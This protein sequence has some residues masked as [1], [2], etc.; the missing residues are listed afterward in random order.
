MIKFNRFKDGKAFVLTMSYDD[1][2]TADRRL[3]EIFNKYGIK[4][5]FHLNSGFLGVNDHINADEVKSLYE[6]HEVSCHSAHHPFLTQ[7][8]DI[9][10]M[11]EVLEDRKT[12]E[13]LCGYVVRGMSYPYGVYSDKVIEL[14]KTCGIVYNRK[15]AST[16]GYQLPTNFMTWEPT[17]HHNACLDAAKPFMAK[18]DADAKAQPLLFYVWGHSYEFN[19]NDNWEL[20]EEFCKTVGGRD[21]VW[22]ATNIEIYDYVMAQRNLHIAA[23]E[24]IIHNPSR[25]DV[26]LTRESDVVKIPAGETVYF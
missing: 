18:V 11:H 17:C 9:S 13:K 2:R 5:T 16:M 3:V 22:Y 15:V 12:L 7:L 4:G 8:P 26:W 21:N 19:D 20:I 14:I 6:G 23:D 1:G 25:I 24:S 10:V